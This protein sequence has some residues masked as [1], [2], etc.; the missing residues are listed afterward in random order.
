[1]THIIWKIVYTTSRQ[2]KFW[3][4]CIII[5]YLPAWSAEVILVVI[6]AAAYIVSIAFNNINGTLYINIMAS[7]YTARVNNDRVNTANTCCYSIV[8]FIQ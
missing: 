5:I 6:D 4:H 8:H 7:V 3:Q 1:M 2:I